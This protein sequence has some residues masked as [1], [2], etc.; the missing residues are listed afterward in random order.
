MLPSLTSEYID[1]DD[2][3]VF[4]VCTGGKLLAASRTSGEAAVD[5]A[6]ILDPEEMDKL[7]VVGRLFFPDL[8][9]RR[10]R[11]DP[12]RIAQGTLETGRAGRAF[13]ADFEEL[14]E[15]E[16][17]EDGPQI[18]AFQGICG[19][20]VHMCEK[21]NVLVSCASQEIMI[22]KGYRQLLAGEK[23]DW[24]GRYE[25]N[26]PGQ[27]PLWCSEEYDIRSIERGRADIRSNGLV[28]S[29]LT[30]LNGR[31]L[32][33][34][35]VPILID[36]RHVTRASEV[37]FHMLLQLNDDVVCNRA[38]M[39]LQD[40]QGRSYFRSMFASSCTALTSTAAYVIG[41]AHVSGH[42]ISGQSKVEGIEKAGSARGS[43]R[44]RFVR[45]YDWGR[46]AL[47]TLS[48]KDPTKQFS[49]PPAYSGPQPFA[50]SATPAVVIA[51]RLTHGL[52]PY[53][54]GNPPAS[55]VQN[56]LVF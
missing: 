10:G 48:G 36:F 23:P 40:L 51:L 24:V 1:F 14:E 16:W 43:S 6:E 47:Q 18:G 33:V 21:T 37:R 46:S 49:K 52:R 22:I 35:H 11:A 2:T 28:E 55:S 13:E 53:H 12:V 54:L 42:W 4:A 45:C 30:I 34:A 50:G 3:H 15:L 29:Q 19:R 26:V 56:L 32:W 9:T 31:A 27:G 38:S 25:L 20:A 39:V 44:F 17:P 8:E 41:D 7:A 5:V